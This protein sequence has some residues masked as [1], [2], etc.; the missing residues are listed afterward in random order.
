[1]FQNCKLKKHGAWSEAAGASSGCRSAA[2]DSRQYL[3]LWH[4]ALL[5]VVPT[6][7]PRRPQ[8]SVIIS[9]MTS[10]VGGQLHEPEKLQ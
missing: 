7:G 8:C 10:M 9:H 6:R 4:R 3:K 1:M 2:P 5:R